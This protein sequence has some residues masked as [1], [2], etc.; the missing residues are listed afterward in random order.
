MAARIGV[1]P[2]QL[3]PLVKPDGVCNGY[4]KPKYAFFT[5]GKAQQALTAAQKNRSV[6]NST[7]VETRYFECTRHPNLLT[8]FDQRVD[9]PATHYHLTSMPE[10]SDGE[11]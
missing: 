3:A 11:A 7:H 1:D 10:V 9:T 4:L 8:S 2:K 6:M 5:E